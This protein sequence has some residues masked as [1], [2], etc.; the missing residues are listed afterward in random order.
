MTARQIKANKIISKTCCIV[1]QIFGTAKRL[2]AMGRRRYLGTHKVH[3]QF[4]L[5]AMCKTCSKQPIRSH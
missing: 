3:A 1:E 4:M 5:K 2:F